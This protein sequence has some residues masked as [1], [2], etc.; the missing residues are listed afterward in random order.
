[1]VGVGARIGSLGLTLYSLAL[2]LRT[3]GRV[4]TGTPVR[5]RS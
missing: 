5:G 2:Y 3:Y 1:M 4:F